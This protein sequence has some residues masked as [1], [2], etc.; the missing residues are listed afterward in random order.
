MAELIQSYRLPLDT[1]A[2]LKS[3]SL[4]KCALEDSIA[5]HIHLLL[6]T[7][8]DE[9]S[10]DPD[11]GCEIWEHEFEHSQI[12]KI[13]IDRMS[14]AMKTLLEKY[15]KRLSD[16]AIKAD[17][18]EKEF[19]SDPRGKGIVR[20][21]KCLTIKLNANLTSTNEPFYYKDSI[22]ISPFSTD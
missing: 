12:S 17:I 6:L 8:Y 3:R 18:S 4:P 14:L 10:F 1:A 5:G 21:Q 19:Q 15:E 11:F 16:I 22:F 9:C 7:A 2:F 20:L 13:W